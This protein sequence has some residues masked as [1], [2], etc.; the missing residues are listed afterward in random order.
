M[1]LERLFAIFSVSRPDYERL[2][3]Q[4][5]DVGFA[6]RDDSTRFLSPSR[7]VCTWLVRGEQKVTV[8]YK[9]YTALAELLQQGQ[10]YYV[11]S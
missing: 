3:G 5:W 4:P 1:P 8:V 2:A 6:V 7:H 10:R 9:G 11:G